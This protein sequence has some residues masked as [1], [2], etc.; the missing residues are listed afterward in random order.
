MK[1]AVIQNYLEEKRQQRSLDPA[2]VQKTMA[3]A[4]PEAGRDN[5]AAISGDPREA[6]AVEPI[7][8]RSEPEASTASESGEEQSESTVAVS[9]GEQPKMPL[10][11]PVESTPEQSVAVGSGEARAKATTVAAISGQEKPR[12]PAAWF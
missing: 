7:D 10:V 2:Y 12:I 4:R 3:D 8:A 5:L 1:S 6:A 11:A 9:R